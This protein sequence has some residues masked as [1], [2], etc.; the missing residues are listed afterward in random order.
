VAVDAIFTLIANAL[1]L[2]C[3]LL[4]RAIAFLVPSSHEDLP[5]EFS[6]GIGIPS[7][8]PFP[9]QV[10]LLLILKLLVDLRALGGFVTVLAC[11]ETV[12]KSSMPLEHSLS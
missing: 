6:A 2:C 3:Y 1:H 5:G 7:R 8:L 11:L 4:Q 10:L 12:S 9:L